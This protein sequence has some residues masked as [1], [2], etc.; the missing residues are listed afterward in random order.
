M[1]M[2]GEREKGV[3]KQ[4]APGDRLLQ[5]LQGRWWVPIGPALP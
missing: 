4:S 5:L 2:H 1:I 3:G